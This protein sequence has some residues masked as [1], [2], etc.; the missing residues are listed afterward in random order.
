MR[1]CRTTTFDIE[2]ESWNQQNQISFLLKL[3]CSLLL[4]DKYIFVTTIFHFVTIPY[5]FR[6][7]LCYDLCQG[8]FLNG[9]AGS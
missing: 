9:T 8:S 5:L 7:C 2:R 1:F 4:S 6:A 3:C